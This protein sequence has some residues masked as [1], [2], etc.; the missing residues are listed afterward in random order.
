MLCFG[1]SPP[2]EKR[3]RKGV[4]VCMDMLLFFFRIDRKRKL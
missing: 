1:L 4:A 3:C 2:S